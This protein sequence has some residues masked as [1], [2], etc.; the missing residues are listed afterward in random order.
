MS[1]KQ[2][3]NK[4]LNTKSNKKSGRAG[5]RANRRSRLQHGKGKNA[6]LRKISSK[7]KHK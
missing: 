2:H 3:K 4:H 7:R 6:F 1:L 5:S